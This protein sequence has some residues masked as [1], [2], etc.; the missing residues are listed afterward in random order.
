M[1]WSGLVVNLEAVSARKSGG[2][3]E[4]REDPALALLV[5]VLGWLAPGLA[6]PDEK[7]AVP[8]AISG[9]LQYSKCCANRVG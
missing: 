1:V 6:G 7:G 3:A 8:A 2:I 5:R 4:E 9:H